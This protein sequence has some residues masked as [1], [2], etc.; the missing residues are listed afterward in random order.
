MRWP[1][2]RAASVRIA[3]QRRETFGSPQ[4]ATAVWDGSQSWSIRSAAASSPLLPHQCWNRRLGLGFLPC[5]CIRDLPQHLCVD[6]DLGQQ[7][8]DAMIPASLFVGFWE[9]VNAQIRPVRSPDGVQGSWQSHSRRT[10]FSWS[11]PLPGLHFSLPLL[12][13]PGYGAGGQR[14]DPD[15]VDQIAHGDAEVDATAEKLARTHSSSV[16]ADS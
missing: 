14:Q 12:F 9:D 1:N 3:E 7:V 13:Q 2:L 11:R 4:I 16:K 10:G 6:G 5:F 15:V 8:D